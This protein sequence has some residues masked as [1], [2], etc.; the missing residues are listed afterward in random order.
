MS[1]DEV[2]GDIH[3]G[4]HNEESL[5]NPS[6]PYSSTK[7][8]ADMLIKAWARTF[9]VPY[10]I[11][12]PTNNYGIGQYPEKLIPKICKSL[13]LNQKIP[14]H[15]KGNPKRVWLHAEDTANAMLSLIDANV[16]NEIFNISGNY[17]TENINIVKKVVKIFLGSDNYKKYCDFSY[18]RVGQDVRYS[19]DDSKLRKLGWKNNKNL[20]EELPSIIQ[21]YKDNFI[22]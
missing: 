3:D 22:W 7:A 1:T 21:H 13:V 2:Y 15:N 9:K 20:D 5:M 4:S 18:S 17:E 8:A 12:R 14:L 11:V 10:I 19:L 16:K 6:N